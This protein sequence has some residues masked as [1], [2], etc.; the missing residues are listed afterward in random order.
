[1][2]RASLH[3]T[4]LLLAA[5]ALV[6]GACTTPRL[7]RRPGSDLATK[8]KGR[9][10]ARTLAREGCSAQPGTFA[11][12]GRCVSLQGDTTLAPPADPTRKPRP[13]P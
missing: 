11:V 2:S 3:R 1:M 8:S 13:V 5:T 10:V 6:A 7:T 4:S 12:D 9:I